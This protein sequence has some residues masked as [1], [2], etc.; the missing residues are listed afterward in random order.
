[1]STIYVKSSFN[2]SRLTSRSKLSKTEKNNCR[3][4]CVCFKINFFKRLSLS[5][6]NSLGQDQARH[7][8]G[9]DLGPNLFAMVINRRKMLSAAQLNVHINETKLT[10]I[11]SLIIAPMPINIKQALKLI[12]MYF[13]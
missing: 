10:Y 2:D 5:F 3:L 11:E 8:V 12:H 4:L 1:M 9:P 13:D 7:L 6:T